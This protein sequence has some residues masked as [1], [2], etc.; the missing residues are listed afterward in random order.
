MAEF[1]SS[2]NP[3]LY[4]TIALTLL[5]SALLCFTGYKFLQILQLSGYKIYGYNAWLRKTPGRYFSRIFML[6]FLSFACMMVFI[7]VMDGIETS[8][9]ASYAGIAFYVLFSGIFIKRMYNAPKKTPLKQ[10]HRMN[11]LIACLVIVN[12]IVNFALL[13]IAN[14]YLPHVRFTIIAITPILLSML[15][16]LSHFIM[17]PIE[18]L[19]N[20]KYLTAAKTRLGKF[21]TLIKIGITGSYGKTSTKYIL[22]TILSEKY[23]VCISPYSFNT[24]MGLTKVVLDYLKPNN[25]I[26]IAEMGARQMGDI[27]KLCDII[28]P[29]YAMLTAVAPQHIDTFGS[30]ENIKKTKNELIE[31]LPVYGYAV[32][33]GNDEICKELQTSCKV[34]NCNT[35][36]DDPTSA[37][38]AKDIKVTSN[39]TEFTAVIGEKELAC[40][41]K[42]I[43]MHNVSNILMCIA[44]AKKLELTDAQIIR[45]IA[46]LKPVAH[47]L[48][49]MNNNGVKILDN[50]YNSSPHSS[51]AALQTLSLFSGRKIVVTPGLIELGTMEKEENKRFGENIAKYADIAIIVNET[52][53]ESILDGLKSGGMDPEKIFTAPTLDHAQLK[54]NEIVK[55]GDIVLFENDLPDNYT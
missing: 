24:E 32:F 15:V 22:N 8:R 14:V 23:S 55:K 5:N 47:R 30:L 29:Q 34:S 54:I 38:Y 31:N 1:F 7:S 40:K 6:S 51:L 13:V 50:S 26:L 11:R 25:E 16:P 45:G 33:N 35:S 52:N 37:V 44:M 9:Y 42:L 43:G 18:K 19:T 36:F 39:S 28:H 46:K 21:P 41:T 48:E 12:I 17:I 10:T 3:H 49:L 2:T 53:R 20:K 4:I 27:R